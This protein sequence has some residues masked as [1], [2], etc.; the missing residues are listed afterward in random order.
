MKMDRK[1]INFT[2][3][4]L[5]HLA[6]GG[7]VEILHGLNVSVS[8]GEILGVV[9]ESGAG[10]SLLMRSLCS[11]SAGAVDGSAFLPANFI[12]RGNIG[13]QDAPSYQH[14]ERLRCEDSANASVSAPKRAFRR[15]NDIAKITMI[16]QDAQS[17]LNPS[18][19]IGQHLVEILRYSSPLGGFSSPQNILDLVGLPSGRA[20]QRRYPHELS[21]GMQQRLA[22]AC[23]IAAN[24]DILIADEALTALDSSTAQQM[25]DIFSTIAQELQ[26]SI[27]LVSHS[28]KVVEKLVDRVIV[29][30]SGHIIEERERKAFFHNPRHPYSRALMDSQPARAKRGLAL[31]DI[32]GEISPAGIR[33]AGCP[34]VLRCSHSQADCHHA[35]PPLSEEGLERYR[36]FHPLK[37]VPAPP[38][39]GEVP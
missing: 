39:A 17:S 19:R 31:R 26:K 24:P 20:F 28:L 32:P 13:F 16:F 7:V 2:D 35:M 23:A 30:Y 29:M 34:F 22:T 4:Y 38:P 33:F 11:L 3:I 15:L 8:Q 25:L 21:G 9:G 36:C 12:L 37:T 1:N 10:K 18:L 27:L 6:P 5:S 14:C